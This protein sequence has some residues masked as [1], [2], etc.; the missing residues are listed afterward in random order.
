MAKVSVYSLSQKRAESMNFPKDYEVEPNVELLAQAVRVLVNRQ[1]QGTAKT[2]TRGEIALTTQ[3]WFRQKGTGRAR[4]GARSAPI[5][6]GGGKAHGPDGRK[7]VLK[8]G[9]KMS[10]LALKSAIS[11]KLKEKK[12][13]IVKEVSS[14][15]KTKDAARLLAQVEGKRVLMLLSKTNAEKYR[16][17][18]NLKNVVVLPFADLNA[19]DAKRANVLVFDADIF[20]KS[21]AKAKKV[22]KT[23]KESK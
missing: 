2:K 9:K 5:F 6:V 22:I 15:K 12:V 21:K 17:F 18:R 7:R 1:H 23:K 20:P 11:L 14:L 16:V 10:A 3:K 4:H 8:M 13:V 19:L